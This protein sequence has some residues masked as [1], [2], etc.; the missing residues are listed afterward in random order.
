MT[1]GLPTIQELSAFGL[2]YAVARDL[3]WRV[4]CQQDFLD[5]DFGG[6]SGCKSTVRPFM[7][8]V[9]G[10]RSYWCLVNSRRQGR[11]YECLSSEAVSFEG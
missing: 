3:S 10:V 7:V 1:S 8:K 5:A 9:P 11:W 2:R 4:L 6:A